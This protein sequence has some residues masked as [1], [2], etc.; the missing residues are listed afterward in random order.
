MGCKK[1]G[2]SFFVGSLSG[3]GWR[4]FSFSNR[5]QACCYKLR[6]AKLGAELR[7]AMRDPNGEAPGPPDFEALDDSKVW[8]SLGVLPP[9]L[10]I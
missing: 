4:C 9:S 7:R 5:Q 2:F 8:G 3:S 1:L 10:T 6:R